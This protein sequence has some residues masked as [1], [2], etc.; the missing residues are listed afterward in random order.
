MQFLQQ[1]YLLTFEIINTH[2]ACKALNVMG[3][4]F[5]KQNSGL[6]LFMFI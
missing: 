4:K 1:C 6:N 3:P 2:D 5:N